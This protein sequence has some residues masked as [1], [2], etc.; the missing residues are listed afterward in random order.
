MNEALTEC[1]TKEEV[2]VALQ[3]MAH[4]KSL[5][6]YGFNSSFYQIYWH[7]V[8]DEVTWVVL[9]FLN[10]DIFDHYTNFT[11]IALIPKVNNLI[12]ASNFRPI[13][14]CNVIYK[15]VS[16]VLVNR[17]KQILSNIISRIRVPLCQDNW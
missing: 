4:L 14:L 3:Q 13:D 15:I 7:I 1:F 16:K 5:G 9:K 8:R 12:S 11:Y 17:L 2:E 10:N 6:P